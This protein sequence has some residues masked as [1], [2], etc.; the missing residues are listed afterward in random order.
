MFIDHARI[1]VKAGQGGSGC[2]SFRREKYVPKGGPDGGDGGNG[3]SITLIADRN[4]STL[5][6][7]KYKPQ[8]MAKR[9]Q[10]GMGSRK[11]GKTAKDL[12]IKVPLGT[13]VKDAETG[14]LLADLVGEGDTFIAARGGRGGRGNTWFATATNQSPRDW[15]VGEEGEERLLE[16]ELKLIADVGLVG[17]PNSGKSTLLA[18]ISKAKPKIADYPFTTLEPNLGIVHYREYQ[19]FVVADIPGLIEGSHKG[20][21]LGLQF[22]RHIERTR[23]LAFLIESIDETPDLSFKTLHHELASFSKKLTEKPFIILI[24]KTDLNKPDLSNHNF[25]ENIDV[26]PFS[27]VTGHNI[28]L[29]IDALYRLLQS[30]PAYE[31]N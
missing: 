3:G 25:P 22:L 13:M 27:S 28:P 20:K 17:F 9:G 7:F 31:P 11:N 4:I 5:I 16:L 23:V 21:G 14:E 1:K 8:F 24:S 19:S 6:D 18:R 29:V 30:V 10:H 2:C 15:E 12:E 26:I